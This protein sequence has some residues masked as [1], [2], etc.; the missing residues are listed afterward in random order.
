MGGTEGQS[1]NKPSP[2]PSGSL[3]PERLVLSGLE[4]EY[5]LYCKEVQ[6]SASHL[7]GLHTPSRLTGFLRNPETMFCFAFDSSS[8]LNF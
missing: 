1:I 3:I 7:E 8:M 2:C 5:D 4:A 6:S